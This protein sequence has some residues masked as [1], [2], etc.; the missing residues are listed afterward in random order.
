MAETLGLYIHIPYC[1]R[2]CAYCDFYS[3]TE[4]NTFERYADALLLHMEDY[5]ESAK[6]RVVDTVFIGGGTPTIL[7]KKTLLSIIDGIYHDFNIAPNVEFTIEANPATVSLGELKDYVKAGV[8]RLSI[9]MQSTHDNELKALS[10]VHNYDEF[11]RSYDIARKAGFNDI[12][13]DVMYGIPQ[14]TKESLSQT[15]DRVLDLDPEHISL[16]G[17]QIEEGTPFAN[18]ADKLILPDEDTEFEM[19]LDSIDKLG[20]SGYEHYEIS[21][22]ARPGYRCAHN[23]KYWNCEE[24]LGLGA[25]AHSYYNGRR[26]SFKPDVCAYIEA[27]E[28]PDS[29]VNILDENYT[30]S[31]SERVGEYVMLRLRLSDGVDCDKF[32]A[33]FGVSFEKLFGKYLRAYTEGGFMQK[34]GHT[35]SLT[36]SGFFVSN[37]ILSTM[38]DFDSDILKGI[39]DGSDK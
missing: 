38:L 29:G 6:N 14:Q 27:L 19:Y 23:L 13:I 28:N 39:A 32:A 1:L 35:Y 2:K 33:L 3:V 10:R 18:M 34:I 8:T 12:N 7:P 36:D 22:F 15:L 30:I 24:Y 17:L 4:Q 5:A 11:L 20:M 37:D 16:Y 26:F 9:G 25:A 31:P 21:N